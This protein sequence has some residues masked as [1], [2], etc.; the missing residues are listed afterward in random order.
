VTPNDS[1]K[2]AALHILAKGEATM[3][4]VAELAGTSRQ[5]VRYWA[6]YARL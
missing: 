3:Q 6:M 5:L 1:T 2:Q 4:E